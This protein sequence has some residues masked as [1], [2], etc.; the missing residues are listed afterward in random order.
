MRPTE[1]LEFD[2]GVV[3]GDRGRRRVVVP[4]GIGSVIEFA[5]GAGIKESII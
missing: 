4:D 5:V 2:D 1:E 3:G